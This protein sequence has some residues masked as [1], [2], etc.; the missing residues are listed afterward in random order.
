MVD[1]PFLKPNWQSAKF[2]PSQDK[3][4]ESRRAITTNRSNN[5]PISSN[6]QVDTFAG[7]RFFRS[8]T[9]CSQERLVSK[10][11][12]CV[13]QTHPQ[14][15]N[16]QDQYLR[17]TDKA[18]REA[19]DNLN[20]L[21]MSSSI[22]LPMSSQDTIKIAVMRMFSSMRLSIHLRDTCW[23]WNKKAHRDVNCIHFFHYSLSRDR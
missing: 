12:T 8:K 5:L 9:N 15:E 11:Q 18:S 16:G 13:E 7:L 10:C 20:S 3:W 21:F 22:S 6:K 14:S 4:L 2:G 23:A 19:F 1:R 17:D